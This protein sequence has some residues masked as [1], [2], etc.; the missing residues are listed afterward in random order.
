MSWRGLWRGLQVGQSARPPAAL[1]LPVRNA[2]IGV[3][4]QMKQQI[5]AVRSRDL[6][7]CPHAGCPPVRAYSTGKAAGKATSSRLK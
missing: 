7:H 3:G 6:H 4:N 5:A 1:E 2:G